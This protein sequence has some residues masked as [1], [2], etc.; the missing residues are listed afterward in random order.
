MVSLTY[1]S[2]AAFEHFSDQ[3]HI[4]FLAKGLEETGSIFVSKEVQQPKQFPVD[5]AGRGDNR[6]QEGETQT[7]SLPGARGATVGGGMSVL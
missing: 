2:I 7:L 1:C 3:T 4:Y 6:E 5:A